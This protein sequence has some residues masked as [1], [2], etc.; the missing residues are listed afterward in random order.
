MS[1]LEFALLSSGYQNTILKLKQVVCLENIYLEIDVMSVLP[2]GY[3]NS[4][5]FHLLLM[6]LFAKFKLLGN[7]HLLWRLQDISN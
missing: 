5:L 6:L 7:L 3:G 2:T 1:C 4:L